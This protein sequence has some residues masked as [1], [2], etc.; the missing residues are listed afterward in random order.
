MEV[1]LILT[2]LYDVTVF[3]IHMHGKNIILD[4]SVL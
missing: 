4:F 1:A 3:S 2:R